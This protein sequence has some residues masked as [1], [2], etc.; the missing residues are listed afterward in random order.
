[1]IKTINPTK[2]IEI[3]NQYVSDLYI[4][5]NNGQPMVGMVRY[6]NNSLEAY[7]GTSWH[8]LSQSFPT[9]GL[10]ETAVK[11]VDWAIKEMEFEAQ[12]EK[13]GEEHPAVKAA[14]ENFRRAAE[15]LKATIILSQDE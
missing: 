10:T 3:T 11:A 5:A 8:K 4:N 2:H 6:H 13:M 7:D 1:M 14:H 12:L 15:Q 9:I